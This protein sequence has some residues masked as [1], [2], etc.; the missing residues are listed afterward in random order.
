MQITSCYFGTASCLP[1]QWG[2]SWF[3]TW[4]AD[5]TAVFGTHIDVI[6]LDPSGQ[7]CQVTSTGDQQHS[8]SNDVHHYPLDYGPLQITVSAACSGSRTFKLRGVVTWISGNPV[9]IDS[10]SATNASLI[11]RSTA[12]TT[13]VPK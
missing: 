9:K 8:I 10:G 13:T 4:P 5:D 11:V 2:D 1:I 3:Q 6:Q 12:S 7:P